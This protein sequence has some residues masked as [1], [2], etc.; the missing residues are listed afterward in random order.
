MIEGLPN[1]H[2]TRRHDGGG[3][4]KF[5]IQASRPGTK[6]DL[7]QRCGPA[8]KGRYRKT[9]PSHNPSDENNF[10][11]STSIGKQMPGKCHHDH[12]QMDFNVNLHLGIAG[13]SSWVSPQICKARR[14]FWA[15][16]I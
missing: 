7:A 5:W 13:E 6:H 15:S 16:S 2:P 4:I 8:I 1:P 9:S 10:H 3:A 11:I 12:F 14:I